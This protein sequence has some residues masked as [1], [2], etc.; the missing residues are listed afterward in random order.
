[1]ENRSIT[2]PPLSLVNLYQALPERDQN[3]KGLFQMLAKVPEKERKTVFDPKKGRSLIVS[4]CKDAG[5]EPIDELLTEIEHELAELE[6]DHP[7]FQFQIADTSIQGIRNANQIV[8]DL[9]RSMLLAIPLTLGVVMLALQS[10]KAGAIAFLPN[11][12]PMVALAATMVIA[13]QTITLTGAAVFVM[14]FGIAVDDTIHTITSFNKKRQAGEP[15]RDSIVNTYNEL[16]G[17]VLSTTAILCGGLGVVMLGASYF[18]RM[19]GAMFCIGLFWALIGD[20]LIL[21]AILACYPS[22][23]DSKLKNSG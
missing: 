15:K 19:F 7:G 5:G 2:G 16:G 20:L 3:P 6:T 8:A 17:A 23:S 18:T 9:I 1:L 21:P 4:R 10:F 13:G 14:C 22:L 11:V 12:F